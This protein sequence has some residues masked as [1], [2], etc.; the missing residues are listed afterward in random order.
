LAS[1]REVILA[2]N[3]SKSFR[4]FSRREGVAG[5]VRDLFHREY[6]EVRAVDGIDLSI[7]EGEIVGYI[8]PNG[9]GKST[10]IK[11]LTGILVPTSG[12]VRVAGYVPWKE[13]EEYTRHIGVV[14]GQRTSLWWDIAV[15][16]SLRLLQ[17]IY[18]VPE[19]D[20][21]ERIDR[22][23]AVL[24]LKEYLHTPTRKLSLGQRMRSELAAA[25]IHNPRVLFLDEPTIGLDVA[26]K[27]RIREFLR[28]INRE[29]RTTILLTTHDIDDI[30]ALSHRVVV[31]DRGTKIY[32]GSL[33]GLK[34]GLGYTRQV[35]VRAEGADV[36]AFRRATA[37]LDA[38]WSEPEPGVF[39]A[40]FDPD[41]TA[42]A[43]LL[44]RALGAA[45]VTDVAIQDVDID[46]VVR[47]IYEGTRQ[48]PF[49]GS[50]GE[51][52]AESSL[53][54]ADPDAGRGG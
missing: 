48:A 31:I 3:L 37:G 29:L 44:Q 34:A 26:V 9:A 49:A 13:R 45:P 52:T 18:R 10:T 33:E 4:A 32:E 14:F 47:E 25:L 22:F 23:D 41:T 11:M 2:R 30:E 50:G 46:R 17:K 36:E 24:G 40:A 35:R 15:I 8:G 38:Q 6:R 20:F 21:R 43:E 42:V 5:A 19:R 27:A 16:E 39:C 12:E 28:E 51:I 53:S 54:S 1:T 7:G